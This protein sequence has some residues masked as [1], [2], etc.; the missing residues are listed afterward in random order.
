MHRTA[1]RAKKFPFTRGQQHRKHD[2]ET[3]RVNRSLCVWCHACT[4]PATGFCAG[5]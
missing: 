3:D 2:L 5:C 1:L 4:G